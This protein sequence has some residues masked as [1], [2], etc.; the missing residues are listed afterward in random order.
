M[1]KQTRAEREQEVREQYK[2]VTDKLFSDRQAFKDFLTFSGKIFK[3][4][5]D[6]AMMIFHVNPAAEMLTDYETWQQLG[7]QVERGQ[8]SIAA[9]ENGKLRHYF[10]I[11]QTVGR[12][13]KPRWT[14]DKQTATELCLEISKNEGKRSA[15]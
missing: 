9:F 2:A 7:R 8:K 5:S 10:D 13:I 4:P 1:A 15:A 6:H 14:L 12:E 3:M 11:S